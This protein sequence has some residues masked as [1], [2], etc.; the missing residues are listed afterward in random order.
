MHVPLGP[1]HCV[2]QTFEET[3]DAW[4]AEFH[5]FLCLDVPALVE[6]DPDKQSVLDGVK[7]QVGCAAG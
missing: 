5:T 4:M 6:A 7:A 1:A 2:L 3:L